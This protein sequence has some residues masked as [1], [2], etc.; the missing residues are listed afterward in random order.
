M[1]DTVTVANKAVRV[2]STDEIL[3]VSGGAPFPIQHGDG[4]GGLRR[5]LGGGLLGQIATQIVHTGRRAAREL[6][7]PIF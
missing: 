3:A 2:L 5:A 7:F 1:R 4:L 6:T